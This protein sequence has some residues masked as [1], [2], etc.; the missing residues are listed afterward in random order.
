LERLPGWKSQEADL[1]PVLVTLRDFARWLPDKPQKAEPRHLWKFLIDRLGRQNLAFVAEPLHDRL[2]QGKVILLLDGLDEIPTKQKRTFIR[3][4][5]A[6]FANRYHRCRIVVTC[7]T[8]S[9]QDPAW[10]LVVFESFT[11]APF[12][13]E[14][15]DQ[16]ITAWYSELVRLGNVKPDAMEGLAWRLRTAMR[17][18]DLWRLAANPLLLTAMA[19]VHTHKGQ[20]PD[21]RALLY[22]ETV[23]ILL[24]RWEQFKLSEEEEAPRLR[25]L[26]T[27]VG[28]TDVDL[29]RALWQ[30]AFVA[31]QQGG[32]ID[33]E[34]V[35]DLGEAQLI[36]TLK[37]LHPDK[38]LDWA[39]QVVEV[40]KLRAGLLLERTPEVYTFPHR[41]FQE[42]LAGAHLAAQPD[43]ARQA[44]RLV[45]EG[46]FWREVV[47]LAVGRLVYLS[48]DTAKPLA[49]AAELCPAQLSDNDVAWRQAWLAGDVLLEIGLNRVSDSAL[50]R[51]LT[52]RIRGCLVGLLHGGHLS[53]V[54]RTA[55]GDTLA[56][57]GDPR[58]RDD[59][60]YLPDDS[61]LGFV[62]IPKGSFV[63]GEGQERHTVTLPRYFMARY[64]VTV[65]QFR[66]F[67]KDDKYQPRDERSLQGPANHPVVY[68]TWHDAVAYCDWLTKRLRAWDGTPEPLATLLKQENW[69]VTLPSEAEWEKAARGK[70]DWIYPWGNEFDPNKAN[71]AETGIN[72]TSAVGCFPAGASQP[73]G[74]M[75]MS[76][77]VWEWTRSLWGKEIGEPEFG[78]PYDPQDK[79]RE[80]LDAP[81]NIRRV[82]RGGACW[83]GQGGARC[84]YRY[85]LAP[86]S[87][88]FYVGFR[89]VVHPKL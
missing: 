75:D 70:N 16:F 39:R 61:L 6:A 82:L 19:L 67:V 34:A 14:Q 25:A 66:Q 73:Y 63:M 5:V 18:P 84:A 2:E 36:K 27:Q 87:A 41:T 76:G 45:E 68:V 43:F 7:R 81:D 29:K 42:Y 64:P 83:H 20:L 23:D 46:A 86:A 89:V 69:Q 3:D 74:I 13:E 47:L 85:G 21:A 78:Y 4:A 65:E 15:I 48:G 11:L 35:A 1:V 52:E 58:F 9:Y 49:L 80:R 56:R 10:R 44:A 26:L 8:L 24:W 62:E 38:S 88:H 57:L 31:H 55:A 37:E 32:T 53:P 12:S 59:A 40:M 30:L 79:R 50:G 28:R 22:E 33:T 60:L 71:T 51:D 77:N 17:R 72:G 54:E